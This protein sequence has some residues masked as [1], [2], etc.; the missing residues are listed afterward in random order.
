MREVREVWE[1]VCAS[2]KYC[3]VSSSQ[4]LAAW[5]WFELSSDRMYT[6]GQVRAN[7]TNPNTIHGIHEGMDAS[8]D[9]W[10]VPRELTER[11]SAHRRN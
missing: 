1:V 3:A 4:S 5:F 9:S 8:A 10:A 6:T 7:A 2:A 11:R